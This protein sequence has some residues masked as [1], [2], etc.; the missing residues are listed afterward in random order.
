MAGLPPGMILH[1]LQELHLPRAGSVAHVAQRLYCPLHASPLDWLVSAG[2]A[3]EANGT[4]APAAAELDESAAPPPPATT[5]R[6]PAP[7]AP[8]GPEPPPTPPQPSS[9]LSTA[10][11]ALASRTSAEAIRLGLPPASVSPSELLR[12][13]DDFCGSLSGG[14]R[15]KLEILRAVLLPAACPSLLLLDEAFGALD[16]I[17]KRMLMGRIRSRC[18]VLTLNTRP[19]PLNPMLSSS[20]LDLK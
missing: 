16:P 12:V 8:E 1:R 17:S 7:D 9:P 20:S 19:Y 6:L 13:H 15:V 11:E 10:R 5:S 3:G 2:G 14:Q 18:A 4:A